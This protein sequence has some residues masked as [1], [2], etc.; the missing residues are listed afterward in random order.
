MGGKPLAVVTA[1]ESLHDTDGWG[2]AHDRLAGLSSNSSH[3]VIDA[4]HAGLLDDEGATG[5]SVS[6]TA[7]VVAAVR[8]QTPVK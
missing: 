6:A 7:A 3:G 1:I 2:A 4:S 5:A 8:T